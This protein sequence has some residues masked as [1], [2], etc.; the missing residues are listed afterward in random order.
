MAFKLLLEC[1]KK[2]RVINSVKEIKNLLEGLEYKDGI[3][4][5][6]QKHHEV[7]AS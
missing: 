5:A 4:V 2:W 3:M 7:V 6:T 1:E